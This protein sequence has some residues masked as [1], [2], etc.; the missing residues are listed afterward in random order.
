MSKAEADMETT[1]FY[2]VLV[3]VAFLVLY[4]IVSG[5]WSKIFG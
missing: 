1:V 4:A 2:L 3:T 5:A